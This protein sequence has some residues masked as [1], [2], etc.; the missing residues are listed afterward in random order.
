MSTTSTPTNPTPTPQAAKPRR[1]KRGRSV[2][3]PFV[4][5]E[6]YEALLKVFDERPRLR[7]TYDRGDLEIMVTS[8]EHEGDS[9]FLAQMIAVLA[10]EFKFQMRSG[11]SGTIK[12]KRMKKGLEPDKCFWL[13]N[14]AKILGVKQLD[15]SVHP[16]PDLAIEVDVSRSSM[17]RLRIYA[18]LGVAEVWRLDGDELHFYALSGKTYNE[19]PTSP[20]FAGITPSDLMTFVKQ[21]RGVDE[22]ATVDAFHAW[23]QQRIAAT[24]AS[25]P[26][27]PPPAPKP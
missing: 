20:T 4:D 1:R 25:P 27:P 23:L 24:A 10:R 16:P 22:L 11:G 18:A 3:I 21:S 26:V 15:L 14:A 19:V 7:L 17:N 12:R 9:A 6:T 2:V 5:W 13:A 8:Q